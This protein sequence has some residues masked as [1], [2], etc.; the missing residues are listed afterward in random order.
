M[1]YT[2]THQTNKILYFINLVCSSASVVKVDTQTVG[3]R[4]VCEISILVKMLENWS[5]WPF[6]CVCVC[7]QVVCTVCPAVLEYPLPDDMGWLKYY[8]A[9]KIDDNNEMQSQDDED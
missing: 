4:V 3:N 6:M 5:V 1:I 8:L 7:L 2:L 9:P